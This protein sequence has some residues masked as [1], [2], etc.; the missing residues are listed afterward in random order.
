LS[1]FNSSLKSSGMSLDKYKNLLVSLGPAGEK[2]FVSLA[3]SI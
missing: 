3:S 2:A 1:K